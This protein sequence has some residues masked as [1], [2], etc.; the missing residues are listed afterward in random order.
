MAVF[1]GLS[2]R[3]AARLG[4][5]FVLVAVIVLVGVSTQ[6]HAAEV[7][8]EQALQ[9]AHDEKKL[10]V[11]RFNELNA[12]TAVTPKLNALT[13]SNIVMFATGLTATTTYND[14]K[15]T[16]LVYSNA[17][18]TTSF[19]ALRP[20]NVR[21]FGEMFPKLKTKNPLNK[22]KMSNQ[23]ELYAS[24]E[25][26]IATKALPAKI[27]SHTDP[28]FDGASYH[29]E[30]VKGANLF[31]TADL[32]KA[33]KGLKNVIGFLGLQEEKEIQLKGSYKGLMSNLS[34]LPFMNLSAAFPAAKIK[35]GKNKQSEAS[36]QMILRAKLEMNMKSLIAELGIGGEAKIKIGN[37]TVDTFIE[38]AVTGQA[39]AVSAADENLYRKVSEIGGGQSLARLGGYQMTLKLAND[40]PWEK[41]FGLPWLT[42]ENYRVVYGQSGA[43][44]YGAISGKTIVGE[45]T[46]DLAAIST[47]GG[48]PETIRLIV[49]DGPNKIGSLST[50]DFAT[51]FNRMSK[52]A[53]GKDGLTKKVIDALPEKI[54]ISGH[55][56][57]EGPIIDI[58][59]PSQSINILGKLEYMGEQIADIRQGTINTADGINIDADIEGLPL[60]PVTFSKGEFK[61]TINKTD[62]PL[63]YIKGTKPAVAGIKREMSA[64]FT[65]NKLQFG[66]SIDANAALHA[67]YTLTGAI[68]SGSKK[69]KDL[70]FAVEGNVTS[71]ISQWIKESGTEAVEIAM[72]KL[73]LDDAM[74]ALDKA[75]DDVSK[76]EKQIDARKEKV[77][78]GR[79][80]NDEAL[81]AAID[82]VNELN[83]TIAL[84]D[85]SIQYFKG[86][87]K[88]CN[89]FKA[90]RKAGCK[91]IRQPEVTWAGTK[92]QGVVAARK[93]AER[94]VKI[95]KGTL[96][97]IPKELDPQLASL[98][99]AKESAMLA[100]NIA[101]EN[102]NGLDKLGDLTA[103]M[104]GK[105][106]D[107]ETISID[108]GHIGGMIGKGGEEFGNPFELDL[109]MRVFGKSVDAHLSYSPDQKELLVK[110]ASYLA[111][112]SLIM[113]INKDAFPTYVVPIKAIQALEDKFI[114]LS[115]EIHGSST[116]ISA[117]E[118]AVMDVIKARG[119][120]KKELE[121]DW[122]DKIENA[123]DAERLALLTEITATL[124]ALAAQQVLKN[125]MVILLKSKPG[126]K[127]I[128]ND[129][130]TGVGKKVHT[131]GCD[132]GNEN[133]TFT[134]K[135]V[136]S[137]APSFAFQLVSEKSGHCLGVPSPKTKNGTDLVQMKCI[138]KYKDSMRN[139]L[140]SEVPAP[141]GWF[142]L[143]VAH[144]SK[145]VDVEGGKTGDKVKLQQYD[146]NN[147]DAQLF[148]I[149]K[150]DNKA[151][152]SVANQTKHQTVKAG[153]I[154]VLQGKGS[155]KCIDQTGSTGNGVTPFIQ[156]CNKNNTNRSEERRVGKE[157]RT[158]W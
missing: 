6:A 83:K 80:N 140:W 59:V 57:G 51:L 99:T 114:E 62:P 43:T 151:A 101:Q 95:A 152:E 24:G 111:F 10:G 53:T 68:K 106:G 88:D 13:L 90:V 127:C 15:Y 70:T 154:V 19:I 50:K 139:Q 79:A 28:F 105:L 37:Q 66:A 87:V 75:K 60:G 110:N 135:E 77:K 12:I 138:T 98:I 104:V 38:G 134:V 117:F 34:T 81:Q 118:S 18:K 71:D 5:A 36:A 54:R 64:Y 129:G 41:A 130:K 119:K 84:L 125:D 11:R 107:V 16:V 149:V 124:K 27:K 144:N 44:I 85:E 67:D 47:P 91:A 21:A 136:K 61:I 143:Q 100:L 137:D 156:P 63:I 145:C 22:L 65:N 142:K 150:A 17:S 73:K 126:G 102:V 20:D 146:C 76:L 141:G 25:T 122:A 116:K 131:L 96:Q 115:G 2:M 32:S 82:K 89:E 26:K 94:A 120:S 108:E 42:I 123:S 46:I 39:K 8:L 69:V 78:T 132:A 92:K 56:K 112:G 1:L 30:L 155:N 147:V 128:D 33:G 55:Q 7:S 74:V 40:A 52:A 153:A 29:I 23:M 4:S 72:D 109:A 86:R 158:R 103:K 97:A 93:T 157:G 9:S 113:A 35:L 45:K 148:Q 3:K 14:R 58:D 31:A 48:M 121:Q 133:Q 49:D